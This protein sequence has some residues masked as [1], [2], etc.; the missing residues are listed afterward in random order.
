LRASVTRPPSR[1]RQP[2]RATKIA[3]AMARANSLNAPIASSSSAEVVC[4]RRPADRRRNRRYRVAELTRRAKHDAAPRALLS[5]IQIVE[6]VLWRRVV[7][8]L[9]SE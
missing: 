1:S 8:V 5:F 3:A 7:L 4:R 2:C 9:A 6:H